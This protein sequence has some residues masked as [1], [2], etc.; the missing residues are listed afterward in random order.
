MIEAVGIGFRRD[1][2]RAFV[3]N[4]LFAS[5][6]LAA[7]L[8]EH[9]VEFCFRKATEALAFSRWRRPKEAKRRRRTDCAA[10]HPPSRRW[11]EYACQR[12]AVDDG[13]SGRVGRSESIG[14]YIAKQIL[15]GE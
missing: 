4:V 6:G 14:L 3:G 2:D 7:A 13:H 5:T 8:G 1:K 10:D 12:T 9:T 11:R 15:Y